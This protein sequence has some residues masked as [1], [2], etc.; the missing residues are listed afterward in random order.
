MKHKPGSLEESAQQVLL[1]EAAGTV[2]VLELVDEYE[3]NAG[4]LVGVF[5]SRKE[6]EEKG[7]HFIQDNWN[8]G[9]YKSF[10]TEAKIG[11]LYH[12]LV[13]SWTKKR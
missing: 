1:G 13:Y 2:Y 11:T 9:K 7:E 6:A 12:S 3:P 5:N 4:V 8:K 10:V